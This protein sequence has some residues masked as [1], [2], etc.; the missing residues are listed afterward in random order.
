[1]DFIQPS[2]LG[3]TYHG[4]DGQK[5]T[6]VVLHRAVTGSTERFL[7][8]LIE[9]YAGAFPLWLA[10]IQAVL[11]PITD[12]N[13]EYCQKLHATLQDNGLRVNIDA[14]NE[15]MNSKIRKAQ[16]Q[17]VPFMLVVG[18]KEEQSKS[19]SVRLRSG[20]NIGVKTVDEF[21][22]LSKQKLLSGD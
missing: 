4:E 5:H 1:M 12:R 22:A 21:L 14:G 9:Q 16:V 2:K 7:G 19:I 15:R 13:I 3:L 18:D 8:V 20:K 10:P 6:P 17:K 11:I